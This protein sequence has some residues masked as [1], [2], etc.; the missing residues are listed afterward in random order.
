MLQLTNSESYELQT[1]VMYQSLFFITESE[2]LKQNK[3][4]VEK[5]RGIEF[6]QGQKGEVE[7]SIHCSVNLPEAEVPRIFLTFSTN[8]PN[9]REF[10]FYNTLH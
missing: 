10:H 7:G 3:S 6:G 1:K 2:K 5:R 8:F 9:E 4:E